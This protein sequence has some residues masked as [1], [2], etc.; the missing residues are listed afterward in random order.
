[1][2]ETEAVITESPAI[3]DDTLPGGARWMHNLGDQPVWVETKT[4]LR[5][6]MA[7][8]GLVPAERDTYSK[9]D[10]SP[11]ATQKYLK[12][13][14]VDPFL[15]KDQQTIPVTAEEIVSAELLGPDGRPIGSTVT[16]DYP[17]ASQLRGYFSWIVRAGYE[18]ELFCANCNNEMRASRMK[19]D[20]MDGHID[21]SC[22]C[23]RIV[24]AGTTKFTK[25]VPTLPPTV[26][27]DVTLVATPRMTLTQAEVEVLRA[28]KAILLRYGLK[29]ALRCNPCFEANR[30]DGVEARVTASQVTIKCRCRWYTFAGY[31][32]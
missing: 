20:V 25:I 32:Y 5:E 30:P 9:D 3:I 7:K 24:Y 23:R 17:T 22:E 29:E 26:P 13:G 21:I 6:E 1:M 28:W 16:L 11:W 2:S 8:R 12:P 4:Q 18:P 19:Y 31:T 15:P 14:A 27:D 10:T